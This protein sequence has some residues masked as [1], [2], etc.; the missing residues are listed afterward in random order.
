MKGKLQEYKQAEGLQQENDDL[1]RQ[2]EG[3]IN[4]YKT[5]GISRED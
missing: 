3:E 5:Q 2:I 4:E 1:R